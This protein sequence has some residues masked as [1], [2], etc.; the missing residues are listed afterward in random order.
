MIAL[1]P[2]RGGSKSIP[3]KNIKELLGKP[4]IAHT[5]EAAKKAKSIEKIIL[6]TDDE[7]IAEIAGNLG[8]E[9]PFM[10]LKEL[11]QDNALSIDTYI[12][13]I[14]RLNKEFGENCEE[15]T[16]LLPTAPFRT[17][18]DI[19]NA[20][21]I[22]YEKGAESVI[23]VCEAPYPPLWTQKIDKLGTLKSYF[24]VHAGESNRQDLEKAYK[25]NGAI[26]VFKFSLLKTKHSFYSEK[27][28][29]YVMPPERSIDIDN[30]LDLEFAEF[31]MKK[32]DCSK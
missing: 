19:D 25:P 23:S 6:S 31:M 30:Y 22:F 3:A 8:A 11:A 24:P 15:F 21:D 1:I 20:V 2:A 9:I 17:A 28:Y 7:K 16:V 14:E 13:T 10:R 12:Y 18:E 4:L 27:T 29:P 32:R 5:I 26:Y